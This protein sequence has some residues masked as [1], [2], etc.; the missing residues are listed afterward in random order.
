MASRRVL[1][2]TAQSHPVTL[3]IFR[4]LIETIDRG[5]RSERTTAFDL[6]IGTT[7]SGREVSWQFVTE[8][9]Q[10]ASRFEI[11]IGM[12]NRNQRNRFTFSSLALRRR[13]RGERRGP[14]EW[15]DVGTKKLWDAGGEGPK[16][17]A[18]SRASV[19]LNLNLRFAGP[20]P[21]V[22]LVFILS[23]GPCVPVAL[24]PEIRW[25]V[26]ATDSRDILEA[27]DSSETRVISTRTEMWLHLH[28]KIN[29]YYL[30]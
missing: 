27:L 5:R 14:K 29:N 28:R 18:R 30:F 2:K 24:F 22:S 4:L 7:F 13:W 15:K 9:S 10:S 17:E 11:Q 1:A 16:E 8:P 19:S 26:Q 20:P 25:F 12:W 3:S 6:K 21:L 23:H